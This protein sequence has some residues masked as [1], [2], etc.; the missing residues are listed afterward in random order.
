M[1]VSIIGRLNMGSPVIGGFG[2]LGL[3]IV[4]E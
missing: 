4:F 2:S 3:F 1:G